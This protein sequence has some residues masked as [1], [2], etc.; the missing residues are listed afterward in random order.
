MGLFKGALL[1]SILFLS[2][3][4]DT[5]QFKIRRF[6]VDLLKLNKRKFILKSDKQQIIQRFFIATKNKSTLGSLFVEENLFGK[7]RFEKTSGFQLNCWCAS[8]LLKRGAVP[9]RASS[10]G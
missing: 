8:E 10:R 4:S 3:C 7:D 5:E 6:Y 9:G 1:W 2:D